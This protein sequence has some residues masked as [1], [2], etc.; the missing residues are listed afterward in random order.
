MSRTV[1]TFSDAGA[2]TTQIIDVCLA[3]HLL[4]YW[5]RDKG[6]FTI[7]QAVQMVTLAP[8][9][10][11]GFAD[12]GLLQPGMAADLNL[13]D[14]KSLDPGLPGVARDLP[15][16]AK[17]LVMKP[18]GIKKTLVGGQVLFEDCEH[19]GALP[20]KLLRRAPSA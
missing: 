10:A 7:E 12:R 18:N 6:A 20:G 15:A 14:L 3:T 11:W 16:S 9:R 8:A 19:T 1:M 2:H 4:S 17:R 5:A 13:I